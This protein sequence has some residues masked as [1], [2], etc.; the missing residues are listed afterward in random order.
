MFALA[1]M[2][3]EVVLAGNASGCNHDDDAMS[4]ADMPGHDMSNMGPMAMN[5]DHRCCQKNCHCAA[6]SGVNCGVTHPISLMDPT[7]QYADLGVMHFLSVELYTSLHSGLFAQPLY[8]PPRLRFWLDV[9]VKG[10]RPSLT[11]FTS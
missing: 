2:P 4:M 3:V 9:C 11:M 7:V 6:C 8:K 5:S 10:A 1:L